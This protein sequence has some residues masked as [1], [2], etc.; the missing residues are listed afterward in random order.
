MTLMYEGIPSRGREVRAYVE[1]GVWHYAFDYSF[2][3]ERQHVAFERDY[4]LAPNLIDAVID[5]HQIRS[6]GTIII[7]EK[8]GVRCG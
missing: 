8:S 3:G 1:N 4:E 6:H 7:P 2:G 5:A